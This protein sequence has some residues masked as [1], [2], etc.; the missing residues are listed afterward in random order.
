MGSPEPTRL[1]LALPKGRVLPEALA[2]LRAA[3]LSL[4]LAADERALRH[5]GADAT[6][7]VMR[8]A[9]VPT[10]V[11]L[12][13]ADAGVVGRD[14]LLEHGSALYAP[15]DLGFAACRLSLIRPVGATGPVRRVA[16]KYPRVTA[17]YLG[18]LGSPAEVVELSGNV[19]L[20]CLSGLAD[21]V[22]DVVQTGATLRANGL[23]EVDV[24]TESSAR[25]VVN[26]AALKL[27]ADVLR[28]LIEAL[29]EK[30]GR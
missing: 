18:R 21:A 15:V 7:L 22:V 14:V 20:A 12:G 2:S 24:I 16:S 23:E 28:P 17:E 4:D 13:V 1:V 10:Y 27:K 5:H 25:L 29:R 26:R 9:D 6:V 3:G 19:E 11:E 30:A 8:N